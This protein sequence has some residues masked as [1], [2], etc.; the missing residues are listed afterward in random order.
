MIAWKHKDVEVGRI[1]PGYRLFISDNGEQR[2]YAFGATEPH[3]A[4][5]LDLRDQL[6]RAVPV[7]AGSD[8]PS[9]ERA[10]EAGRTHQA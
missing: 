6:A 8:D 7:A 4:T 2:R 1:G 5:L 3:D 10:A 9:I